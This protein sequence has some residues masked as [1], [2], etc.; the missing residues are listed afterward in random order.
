[1]GCIPIIETFG[2]QD[3]LFRSFE[4]LPVL[5][6]GHFDN[7]TPGLLEDQYP[8]ILQRAKEYKFEKLTQTNWIELINSY[9]IASGAE[10]VSLS[11]QT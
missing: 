8:K 9:Q 2:R 4:E 5:F 3:G 6:A 11:T 7:V 10:N 1:M